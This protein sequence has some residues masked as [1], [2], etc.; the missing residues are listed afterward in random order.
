MNRET[1]CP[2]IRELAYIADSPAELYGGFHPRA[3]E[4]A[5]HGIQEIRRLRTL[6]L[7]ACVWK[8]M[9][10]S[11]HY[12][13][14]CGEGYCFITPEPPVVQNYRYCPGCGKPIK[15]ERKENEP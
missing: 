14:A 15:V 6:L 4:A 1:E 8:W 12:D 7:E 10:D 2:A 13:T 5:Q 3:R 9:D 11:C